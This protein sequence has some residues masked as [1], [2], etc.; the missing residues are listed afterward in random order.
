MKRLFPLLISLVLLFTSCAAGSYIPDENSTFSILLENRELFDRAVDE[1]LSNG[2]ACTVS[3]T[4]YYKPDEAAEL[5]GTF[6]I[7]METGLAEKYQSNYFTSLSE[8]CSVKV[9]DLV[10]KDNGLVICSFDFCKPGRDY[11]YGVYYVSDDRPIFIGD[12]GASLSADQNGFTYTISGSYGAS[13]NYYTEK[14]SDH[15]Y[16]YEIS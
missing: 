8:N 15:Y 9:I 13:M 6:I 11:D 10:V 12:P 4:V 7:N 2:F 16:Y 14:I 1:T 5:S 3:S